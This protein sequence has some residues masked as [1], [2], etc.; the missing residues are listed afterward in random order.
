MNFK[1][2][3]LSALLAASLFCTPALAAENTPAPESSP[4]QTETTPAVNPADT[5]PAGTATETAKVIN[6]LAKYETM[7]EIN[8]A[9]GF[10]PLYV[11]R[12]FGYQ[13]TAM[14]V[15]GGDLAQLSFKSNIDDSTMIV[16]T[17]VAESVGTDEISGYY[18]LNWGEKVISRT[19]TKY[20]IAPNSSIV[21]SWTE[22]RYAFS[23]ICAKL[24]E[25]TFLRQMKGLVRTS[26]QRYNRRK[27]SS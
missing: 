2:K 5:V 7:R 23:V 14:Y 1:T 10:R 17:A 6:P 26:E 15:I 20:A 11:P 22:G 19:K 21:V 18:G 13:C 9:L 25:E 27:K 24:D 16:R 12:I 4:T 8:A 3:T